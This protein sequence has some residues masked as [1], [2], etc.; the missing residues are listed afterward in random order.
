MI[1]T[2]L[3][4]A[5]AALPSMAGVLGTQT[6]YVGCQEERQIRFRLSAQP[7]PIIAL[8]LPFKMRSL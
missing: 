5:V 3:G 6:H 2:P 8:L 1:E 4:N 7:L